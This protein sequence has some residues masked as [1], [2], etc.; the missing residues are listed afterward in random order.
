M[1]NSEKT[2][3]RKLL[4]LVTVVVVPVTLLAA[5]EGLLR[6]AGFGDSGVLFV[7]SERFPDRLEANPDVVERF[8]SQSP[9]LAIDPIPFQRQKP[10]GSIRIVVQGGSTAAG[11]PY[12]RWAGL[13]GMLGDRL[14][15][16]FPDREIEVVTT[17]MAAVNSYA[18]LD[19][20][21]EII[22]IE[23]DVVLIYAGHNEY[24]G[25]LGVA[26]GL[27]AGGSREVVLLRLELGRLRLYQALRRLIA[28]VRG[29]VSATVHPPSGER[30]T[31][32]QQAARGA[33]V[34]F[35]SPLD[36]RGRRQFAANLEAI[37]ERYQRAGIPVYVGTLASN[38]RDQPPFAGRNPEAVDAAAWS[39]AR[40]SWEVVSR[41]GGAAAARAAWEHWSGLDP[42][43]AE[44][45]FAL[46]RFAEGRGEYA[47]AREAY[48]N[49]KDRDQL[50]FRAPEVFNTTIRELAGRFGATVVDVQSHFAHASRNGITGEQ[51]LLEH[52]HPNALGYFWLADA[53]YEALEQDG[54]IGDWS[55]APTRAAAMRSM[56]ITAVDRLLA[57]HT[58]R[59]LVA[60]FPF[61]SDP[62]AVVFPEPRNEVERIAKALSDGELAWLDAM[63]QL[64]RIH[65][66]A[67][68]IEAAATVAR[69]AA[70]A[71]PDSEAANYTAAALLFQL[72]RYA[73]AQHYLERCLRVDPEHVDA[74]ALRVRID[75]ALGAPAAERDHL[76]QL[77][78]VAPSHPLV[79]RGESAAGAP[80]AQ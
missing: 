37:L 46:G 13:A 5:S 1:S 12:G 48:R 76:S 53:Y 33:Q 27:I 68:R 36:R 21:D 47:V 78:R 45:W 77:S 35:D 41:A 80:R 62:H 20:V 7:E 3:R 55:G 49:A 9:G 26:S 22:A 4:G 71:M 23:P 59:E 54:L 52:V 57:E 30:G 18:L 40:D 2:A 39:R 24:V 58:I 56:P 25:I 75:R 29:V 51:L 65:R 43:A 32:I 70:Q 38:E 63:E 14:E 17:A 11:F 61:T 31:L 6:V 15:A 69:I 72:E 67:G 16:T 28:M 50:R 73:W 8:Y 74:L 19:F 44:P 34:V 10:P 64:L 66:R 42:G 79:R 60:R